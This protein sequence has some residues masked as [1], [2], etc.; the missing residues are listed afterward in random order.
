MVKLILWDLDGVLIKFK[1][2]HKI[3]LNQ[4]L[5]FIGKEYVITEEDHVNK[6]DG[7]PTKTKLDILSSD[8][9]LPLKY[10]DIIWKKKQENTLR[11]IAE[12]LSED[13]QLKHTFKQLK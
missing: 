2:Q 12:T 8:R 1:E 7:L 3:A 5:E 9:G 11:L 4:A 10:H 13:N 6:F